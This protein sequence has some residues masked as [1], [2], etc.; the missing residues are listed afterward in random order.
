MGVGPSSDAEE[1][2]AGEEEGEYEDESIIHHTASIGDVEVCRRTALRS[3]GNGSCSI[4][5]RL[6]DTRNNRA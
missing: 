3:I 2:A 6:T 1:E 5:R 4:V